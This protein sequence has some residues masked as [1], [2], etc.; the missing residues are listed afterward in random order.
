VEGGT[1]QVE[2]NAV[3]SFLYNLSETTL[4]D[5]LREIEK[6]LSPK[7]SVFVA[8]A[9]SSHTS[10][11]GKSKLSQAARQCVVKL[12]IVLPL[13]S[14]PMLKKMYKEASLPLPDLSD[15]KDALMEG[16]VGWLLPNYPYED[17]YAQA[18]PEWAG[19]LPEALA[20]EVPAL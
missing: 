13:L 15:D 3:G 5:A 8:A 18:L 14:V 9:G 1:I 6:T 17:P 19:P 2:L 20:E 4:M 7:Q 16:L 12:K 11:T 10:T